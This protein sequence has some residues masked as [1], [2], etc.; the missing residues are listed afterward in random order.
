MRKTLEETKT[1]TIMKL[2]RICVTDAE[3]Y[4]K[5]TPLR[6]VAV[7]SQAD[8]VTINKKNLLYPIPPVGSSF[9]NRSLTFYDLEHLKQ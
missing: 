3:Q 8:R 2:L 4:N 9:K 5:P 6:E 7:R 1:I